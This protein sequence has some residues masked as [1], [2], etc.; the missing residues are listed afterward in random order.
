MC[1]VCSV[2]QVMLPL[3]KSVLH[4]QIND[5]LLMRCC[6][7]QIGSGHDIS[8]LLQAAKEKSSVQQIMHIILH[9]KR[10]ISADIGWL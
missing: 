9:S 8:A 3:Q 6:A 7:L 4:T 10:L 1:S 2:P 5:L